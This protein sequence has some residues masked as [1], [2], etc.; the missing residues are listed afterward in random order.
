MRLSELAVANDIMGDPQALSHRYD[1]DGCLLVRNAFGPTE[2][3]AIG[4]EASAVL[5]RW[6]VGTLSGEQP[7]LRWTG[8][9]LAFLDSKEL[10]SL[11]ALSEQADGFGKLR[12]ALQTLFDQLCGHPMHLWRGAHFHI[13]IPDDPAYAGV[14]HQDGYAL[15][16]TGDYR[17][18][19][20]TLTH[21]PFGDGGLAFARGSH[22]AGRFPTR[23]LPGTKRRAT[24]YSPASTKPVQGVGPELV[25]D[26]WHTAELD[27]GDA[28]VFSS[29][30]VHRGLPP[31]SDRIR[32]ALATVASGETDPRPA[33]TFTAMEDL[34]RYQRIREL[35]GPLGLSPEEILEVRGDLLMTG[36][37]VNE[38]TVRS[39]VAGDHAGW[40]QHA[41]SCQTPVG[42]PAESRR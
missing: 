24:T 13:T 32:M 26:H 34:E 17:R 21:I 37:P 27:P 1:R 9:P 19:W 2:I 8:R 5:E 7:G 33:A 31:T 40:R 22:R 6:G 11:P 35:G 18:V 42:M 20:I 29:E 38:A 39:A 30:L 23:E 14:P 36:L 28:F 41:P 15:S 25:D 10:H 16:S 12:G 3:G 4:D